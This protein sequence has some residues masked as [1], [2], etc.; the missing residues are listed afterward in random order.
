MNSFPA[1]QLTLQLEDVHRDIT[2]NLP[3]ISADYKPLRLQE[4]SPKKKGKSEQILFFFA[5]ISPE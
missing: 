1:S 3:E 2:F 5:F 4:L